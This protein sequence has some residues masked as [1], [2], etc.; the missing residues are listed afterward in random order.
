[1]RSMICSM[2]KRKQNSILLTVKSWFHSDMMKQR[3]RKVPKYLI[4]SALEMSQD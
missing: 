1:M 3:P 4:K 2:C